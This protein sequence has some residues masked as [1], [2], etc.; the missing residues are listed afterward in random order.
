MTR[1]GNE[2]AALFLKA[3]N[4]REDGFPRASS[5]LKAII[6]WATRENFG[7]LKCLTFFV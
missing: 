6:F 4:N 2:I 1:K 5:S 3:R 7:F